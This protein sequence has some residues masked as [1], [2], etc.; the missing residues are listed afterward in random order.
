M[1]RYVRRPRAGCKSRAAENCRTTDLVTDG[2][3]AGAGGLGPGSGLGELEGELESCFGQLE[4]AEA[5]LKEPI[6]FSA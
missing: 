3:G 1:R 2:S 5:E 6:T 4:L